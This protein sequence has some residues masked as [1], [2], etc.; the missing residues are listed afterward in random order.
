MNEPRPP[1]KVTFEIA[2]HALT[3]WGDHIYILGDIPEL[4]EWDPERAVSAVGL[5]RHALL[6]WQQSAGAVPLTL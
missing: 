4:G 1:S 2:G 5:E 6:Q 3:T